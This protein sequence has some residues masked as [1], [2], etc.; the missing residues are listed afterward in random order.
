MY[1][2]F[3]DSKF[4]NECPKCGAKFDSLN[5]DTNISYKEDIDYEFKLICDNCGHEIDVTNEFKNTPEM[6]KPECPECNKEMIFVYND[7]D[8]YWEC[9]FCDNKYIVSDDT[10]DI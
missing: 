3:D 6:E 5:L 4:I 9:E 10:Y 2:D 7:E 1:D 8:S